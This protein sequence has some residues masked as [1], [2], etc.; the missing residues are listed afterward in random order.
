MPSGSRVSDDM[1]APLTT[2]G[3]GVILVGL[4]LYTFAIMGGDNGGFLDHVNL[5]FHEAGHLV[6]SVF[7]RFAG[8]LG[9]TLGQL[10]VPLAVMIGFLRQRQPFNACLALWWCGQNFK[11]ISIYIADARLRSLP[12]VGGG[13]HDWHWMLSRLGWLTHDRF[14]GHG[15]LLTGFVIMFAALLLAFLLL[16]ND[17]ADLVEAP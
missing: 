7:G 3:R 17:R 8:F 4:L 6:F 11:G 15:V 16:L 2:L 12:L 9:G 10:L 14:L 13:I 5:V 1:P